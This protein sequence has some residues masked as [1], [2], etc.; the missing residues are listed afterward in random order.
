MS[1]NIKVFVLQKPILVSVLQQIV[2]DIMNHYLV[3]LYYHISFLYCYIFLKQNLLFKNNFFLHSPL[4]LQCHLNF[5]Q[6]N[7]PFQ[8]KKKRELPNFLS[9]SGLICT[10]YINESNC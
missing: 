4:G 10:Q 7:T 8:K 2:A 6:G 3:I 1:Q 9:D 5:T